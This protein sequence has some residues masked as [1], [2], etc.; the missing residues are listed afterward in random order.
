MQKKSLFSILYVLLICLVRLNVTHAAELDL[1]IH[2]IPSDGLVVTRIS[3]KSLRKELSNAPVNRLRTVIHDKSKVILSQWIPDP[4][5]NGKSVF[6]GTLIALIPGRNKANLKLSVKFDGQ[7]GRVLEAGE[8]FRTR[9]AQFAFSP[10]TRSIFPSAIKFNRSSQSIDSFEWNDRIFNDKEGSSFLKND[11]HARINII[12]AG[13]L[14]DVVRGSANYLA[15]DG[16]MAPG[17]PYAIYDWYFFKN[18]PFVKVIARQAAQT[19]LSPHY[20]SENH[21]LEWNFKGSHFKKFAGNA[22]ASVLLE[23]TNKTHGFK[24]WAAIHNDSQVIGMFASEIFLHDGIKSYGTYLHLMEPNGWLDWGGE[25]QQTATW[26]WVG[27]REDALRELTDNYRQ[28]LKP[29]TASSTVNGIDIYI[30]KLKDKAEGLPDVQKAQSLWEAGVKE[31]L[32]NDGW[33]TLNDVERKSLPSNVRMFRSGQLG[34]AFYVQK[35]GFQLISAYDLQ[36]QQELVSAHSLPLLEMSLSSLAENRTDKIDSEKGWARVN[37]QEKAWGFELHLDR[38]MKF[39]QNLLVTIS[40]RKNSEKSSWTWELKVQNRLRD[41]SIQNVT[42]PQLPMVDLGPEMKVFLPAGP[43]LLKNNPFQEPWTFEANYPGV[44]M[45]YMALYRADSRKTG[46]YIGRH[47]PTASNK[48]LFARPSQQF[49]DVAM[50][51]TQAAENMTRGGN[52][53]KYQGTVVWQLLNGDWYDAAQ[54]YRRWVVAHAPWYPK[55]VNGQRIDTPQWFKETD[56]WINT[57][58]NNDTAVSSMQEVA[59]SVEANVAGHWYWWHQIPFDNDY[60]HYFPAKDGFK[61]SVKVLQEKNI[62]IM[63]YVNARLWDTRDRGIEDWKYINTAYAATTKLLA[64]GQLVPQLE[65]SFPIEA[66]GKNVT[67]AVMCPHTRLWQD[68]VADIAI[69]L[70]NEV[71]VKAVYLDQIAAAFPVQC[72]DSSHGHPLG[73]GHWWVDGYN[74]M[75]QRIRQSVPRDVVFTSE[76]NS[77]AY[78]KYMN[79]ALVWNW[80]SENMVPAYPVVYSGAVQWLG[81]NYAYK[82]ISEANINTGLRM[83]AGQEFAWGSQ[84]GW[85]PADLMLK[86]AR[87][88]SRKFLT[89]VIEQRHKIRK[90]FYAGEMLRPPFLKGNI[91]NLTADWQWEGQGNVTYPGVFSSAWKLATDRR[92]IF[93]LCNASEVPVDISFKFDPAEYGIDTKSYKVADNIDSPVKELSG[94]QALQLQLPA[95]T[96]VVVEVSF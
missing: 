11:Q 21:F 37:F 23:D 49:K 67:F 30:Q 60:P 43:G 29:T 42:F 6:T 87:P 69:N 32:V 39:G 48:I 57:G 27:E 51:Y 53:F 85:F 65:K 12:S 66:D 58:V 25:F 56:L 55:I 38:E 73:G 18:M 86:L 4:N 26:L 75:L 14:A 47:D 72:M 77:E 74:R 59:Q 91:P 9:D 34:L 31:R 68:T 94:K 40:A 46:F 45:Q 20:W 78:M 64:E 79:G 70:A 90:Y 35:D 61:K 5:F 33:L 82:D 96:P 84:M 52:N 80:Q 15:G 88:E 16:R 28:R 1:S 92:M 95:L 44:A 2:D 13:P 19:I 10:A 71:G 93:I 76:S 63:P 22:Q 81:R 17:K 7:S 89:D 8:V 41:W 36:N 50:G 54:I 3:L 62:N 83:K 24:E